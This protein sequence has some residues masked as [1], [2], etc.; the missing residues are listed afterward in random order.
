MNEEIMESFYEKEVMP[1]FLETKAKLEKE[2]VQ[3]AECWQEEILN[4]MEKEVFPEFDRFENGKPSYLHFHMLRTRLIK[5]DYR[6]GIN[7]YGKDWFL[8]EEMRIAEFPVDFIFH[9]FDELWERVKKMSQRYVMQISEVDVQCIMMSLASE[10]NMYLVKLLRGIRNR[11]TTGDSYQNAPKGELFMILCGEYFD[12]CEFVHREVA[13][14]DEEELKSMLLAKRQQETYH[15]RDFRNMDFSNEC[16][17]GY[18]FQY[19]DFRGCKMEHTVFKNC[20]FTGA[21]LDCQEQSAE[22]EDCIFGEG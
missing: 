21:L 13:H 22:F 1:A 7:L 3:K 14:K 5:R 15:F 20:D 10:F 4:F 2:F 8:K 9:Y 19:I 17:E 11:L 16:Y 18:S 12:F 6:Y